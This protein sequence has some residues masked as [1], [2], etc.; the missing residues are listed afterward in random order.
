M[1]LTSLL[2]SLSLSLTFVAVYVLC[3]RRRQQQQQQQDTFLLFALRLMRDCLD[4]SVDALRAILLLRL[5]MKFIQSLP[6]RVDSHLSVRLLDVNDVFSAREVDLLSA[7]LRSLLIALYEVTLFDTHSL[8]PCGVNTILHYTHL[9][10]VYTT[11]WCWCCCAQN[12]VHLCT[13]AVVVY[14]D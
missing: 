12:S 4:F 14:F 1:T 7:R 6:C 8:T 11:C 13:H 9:S 5:L 3:G 10:H 2:P